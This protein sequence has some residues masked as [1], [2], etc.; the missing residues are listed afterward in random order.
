MVSHGPELVEVP[1]SAARASTP[2][3]SGWRTSASRSRST[4]A[5]GYLGLGYVFGPNPS[6]GEMVP[7]GSTITL[8]V[9]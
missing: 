9:I 5:P 8:I 4:D 1:R 6:A 7:K 3:P 2:R